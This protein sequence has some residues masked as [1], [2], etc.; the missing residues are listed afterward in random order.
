M[1]RIAL[2][3]G[4]DRGLGLG[5]AKE[6]LLQNWRVYAGQY[7]PQWTEL[8]ELATRYPDQLIVHS[9][10]RLVEPIGADRSAD[11][12]HDYGPYRYDRQ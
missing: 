9:A 3:T 6:L 5:I 1:E 2:V 7:I 11:S 12:L 4:A 8:N 10:G